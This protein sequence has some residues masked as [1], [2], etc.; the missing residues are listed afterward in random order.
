MRAGIPQ[1]NYYRKKGSDA[2][3]DRKPGKAGDRRN[4]GVQGE[5]AAMGK[6]EKG[7]ARQRFV[8]EKFRL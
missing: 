3:T 7:L 2:Q 1:R 8:Y 6:G 5:F 4:A